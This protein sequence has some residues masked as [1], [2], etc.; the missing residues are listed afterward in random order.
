MFSNHFQPKVVA[1]FFFCWASFFCSVGS[2][3]LPTEERKAPSGEWMTKMFQFPELSR[4]RE[5]ARAAASSNNLR[6]L[7][8]TFESHNK[9]TGTYPARA[10]FNAEGKPLLSWRVE[11]LKYLDAD[12]YKQFHLNEP[13]DS[14]HNQLLIPKM[15]KIYANPNSTSP[16][17]HTTYLGVEGKGFMFSGDSGVKE[18]EITDGFDKTIR[19]VEV[20]SDRAV[21]WTKPEDWQFDP[22]QP[23][24]GLGKA[25]S[26]FFF[27]I[28]GRLRGERYARTR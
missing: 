22:K 6:Q 18:A 24:S 20:D 5:A 26:G 13:W 9:R 10:I 19:I 17:G 25:H 27:R 2:A 28:D 8:I 15:P 7:G 21:I 16:R 23:L 4:A 14:D 3:Q 11:L 12:L 1:G